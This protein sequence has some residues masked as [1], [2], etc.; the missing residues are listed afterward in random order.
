MGEITIRVLGESAHGAQPHQGSDAILA[1]AAVIQGL[2][3][4]VSRNISPLSSAVITFGKIRGG[5]A[6]NIIPGE[7]VLNGNDAGF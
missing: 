5:D 3:A 4:I 7:V 2:H 1:A 6:E